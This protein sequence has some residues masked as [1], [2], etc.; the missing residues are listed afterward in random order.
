MAFVL[1]QTTAQEPQPAFPHLDGQGASCGE[2]LSALVALH[3]PY[4]QWLHGSRLRTGVAQRVKHKYHAQPSEQQDDPAVVRQKERRC[5]KNTF[6]TN[7]ETIKT[8]SS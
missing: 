6:S 5:I 3:V 8:L 7:Y 2:E 4:S 1:R